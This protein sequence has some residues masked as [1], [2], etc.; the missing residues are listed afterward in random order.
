MR[1]GR[2]VS[3]LGISDVLRTLPVAS[4]DCVFADRSI[5]DNAIKWLN[6]NRNNIIK[7]EREE[8]GNG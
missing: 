8:A 5:F 6:E 2:T 7:P 3:S 1:D 4:V